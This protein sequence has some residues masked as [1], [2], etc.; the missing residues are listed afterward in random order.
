MTY[1]AH[2]K[3]FLTKVAYNQPRITRAIYFTSRLLWF[4]ATI[5]ISTILAKFAKRH[6]VAKIALRKQN[7]TNSLQ[8]IH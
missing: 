2:Y 5:A 7:E 8:R 3:L 4:I 6:F 1:F